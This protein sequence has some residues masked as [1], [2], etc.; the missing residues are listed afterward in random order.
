M[1]V[2]WVGQVPL[3]CYAKHAGSQLFHIHLHGILIT[4]C[5]KFYCGVLHMRDF[6]AGHI[7]HLKNER[8]NSSNDLASDQSSYGSASS[9]TLPF[10]I[11][12]S[13]LPTRQPSNLRTTI[14][15]LSCMYP[16]ELCSAPPLGIHLSI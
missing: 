10:K 11:H 13:I 5:N 2:V 1:W 3:M 6:W 8:L 15:A 12:C 4:A 7:K 14:W 16:M 9:C